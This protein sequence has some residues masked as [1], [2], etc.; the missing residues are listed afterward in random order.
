MY[1]YVDG[2]KR[3]L[4][5]EWGDDLRVFDEEGTIT[6]LEDLPEAEQPPDYPPPGG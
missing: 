1:R 4:V 6:V 5:D 2:A 3:Y